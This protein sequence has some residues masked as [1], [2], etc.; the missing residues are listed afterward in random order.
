M[1]QVYELKVI[2]MVRNATGRLIDS[3]EFS[4]GIYSTYGVAE[5]VAQDLMIQVPTFEAYSIE[6]RELYDAPVISQDMRNAITVIRGLNDL[7]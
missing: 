7:N 6:Q 3:D 2:Q 1:K 5:E 4:V